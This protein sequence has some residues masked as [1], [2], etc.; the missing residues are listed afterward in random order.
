MQLG[1]WPQLSGRL[2]VVDVN[3]VMVSPWSKGKSA[4]ETHE[5][6][7]YTASTMVDAMVGGCVEEELQWSKVTNHLC[8]DP[9]LIEK[10]ELL[11]H[12]I[13]WRGYDQCQGQV[14]ELEGEGQQFIHLVELMSCVHPCHESL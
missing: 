6:H 12:Q 3:A 13:G 1:G 7:L 10:V 2:T 11:V 4:G 8:M 5:T 14:E 9:E